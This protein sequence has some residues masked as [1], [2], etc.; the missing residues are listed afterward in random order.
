MALTQTQLEEQKKQLLSQIDVLNKSTLD[1]SKMGMSS[2]LAATGEKQMAAKKE[3]PRYTDKYNE[4]YN[5]I[6]NMEFTIAGDAATA[7]TG[8][9][10]FYV[11]NPEIEAE[12][13]ATS[14][15]EGIKK[16]NAAY[17][18]QQVRFKTW[19]KTEETG[20]KE[21]AKK[22]AL[23]TYLDSFL[24]QNRDLNQGIVRIDAT[25]M[26]HGSPDYTKWFA[27]R[28][29]NT[30]WV[31]KKDIYGRDYREFQYTYKLSPE[32]AKK[33]KDVAIAVET[34]RYK[35]DTSLQLE[36]QKKLLKKLQGDLKT[37]D[38]SLVKL[39]KKI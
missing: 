5:Q 35:A 38:A 25:T 26:Y 21:Q 3:V 39:N 6:K 14:F 32:E 8:D 16:T 1:Y 31:W 9:K 11:Y 13:A 30:E 36:A 29:R 22:L 10:A 15:I 24:E 19:L 33:Q 7:A 23:Q 18:A 20:I 37:V 34:A 17:D 27:S 4:I 2:Y 28:D 12:K